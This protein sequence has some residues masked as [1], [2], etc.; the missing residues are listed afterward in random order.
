MVGNIDATGSRS[1]C[2]AITFNNKAASR[3]VRV[4]HP[5]VSRDQLTGIIP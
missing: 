1:S 2:P 4:I 5:A 3:T